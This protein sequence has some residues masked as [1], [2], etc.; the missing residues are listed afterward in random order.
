[1]PLQVEHE[2]NL[3]Q[4]VE[5]VITFLTSLVGEIIVVVESEFPESAIEVHGNRDELF[6][7]F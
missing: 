3:R 1:M 5:V 2:V 6:Q 4:I 7:M